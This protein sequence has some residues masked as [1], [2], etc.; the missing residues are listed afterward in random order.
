MSGTDLA[1]EQIAA[2]KTGVLLGR[3]LQEDLGDEIVQLYRSGQSARDIVRT[4]EI[5]QRYGIRGAQTGGKAILFALRGNKYDF[6]EGGLCYDGLLPDEELDTLGQTHRVEYSKKNVRDKIG[7]FGRTPEQVSKA[8]RIGG[9]KI[10]EL[11]R[12]IHGINPETGERYQVEGAKLGGIRSVEVR[13]HSLYTED[14][15]REAHELSQQSDYQWQSGG[16]EGRPNLAGKPNLAKIAKELERRGYPPRTRDALG[17]YL[18]KYRSSLENK[19][20]TE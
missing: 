7:I 15:L 8:N 1:P 16:Q 4:L 9:K 11:G 19:A 12:G 14:E 5:R 13:G 10:T 17:V 6:S 2:I 18:G 3:K 20:Q